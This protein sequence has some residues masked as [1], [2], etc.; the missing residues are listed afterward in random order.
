ML[1][2]AVRVG[3]GDE[4][5]EEHAGREHHHR[6]DVDQPGRHP[7]AH[8]RRRQVEGDGL[9][10]DEVVRSEHREVRCRHRA[11]PRL[12]SVDLDAYVLAHH[13]EWE[14]L[15]A[16]TRKRRLDGRESDELV[17]RY[18]RVATHLSVI[19]TAAPDATVIT[20]LS[21][22]AQPG[23]QPVRRRAG[24]HLA[25]RPHL[26]HRALPG[27]S[28]PAALVVD[29]DGRSERGRHLRDDV[30][31]ARPSRHGAEPADAARRRPAGQPRL[32]RLLQQYAAV[33]LR[34]GGLDQQRLGRG[35]VPG[36]RRPRAA[37]RLPAVPE[38]R[39]PRDHRLDHDPARA[40]P[41]VLGAD[42]PARAA[43]ADRGVRGRRG[44][45]AAVLVVGRAGRPHPGP[46]LR[47]RGP[48]RRDGRPRTGRCPG[49][50]R[51]HR[52]VRDARRS[53]P[54]WARIGIGILAEATFLAYVFVLGRRAVATGY[55][56]DVDPLLLDDRVASQA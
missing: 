5:Q 19:R 24:R 34:R 36:P 3:G 9:A 1:E 7:R 21:L 29:R 46:V 53:L 41:G 14:R 47:P 54:T 10:R 49:R 30:V 26:R 25:R 23:A 48:H 52:G 22:A 13:Q 45:A 11:H 55:T 43:R 50:Q 42:P 56:G 44:R 32:R 40:R 37:R 28:L 35:P 31:A 4:R 17:E 6:G 12:S 27:C 38:R 15:E 51:L 39:E 20:Y 18:Q 33:P 16:L 2:R 8:R